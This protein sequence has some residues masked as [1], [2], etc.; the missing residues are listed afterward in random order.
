M[1]CSQGTRFIHY[2]RRIR[3]YCWTYI[4]FHRTIWWFSLILLILILFIFWITW[5]VYKSKH[6]I[7]RT[8]LIISKCTW[9]SRIFTSRIFTSNKTIQCSKIVNCKKCCSTSIP[10]IIWH[11]FILFFISNGIWQSIFLK[12]IIISKTIVWNIKI[13][14]FYS[15]AKLMHITICIST[16]H[17]YIVWI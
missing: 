17:I 8:W 5:N 16:I 13:I 14:L 1:T 11:T 2:S 7:I 15:I 6:C 12:R 9:I 10:I 3:A 4:I